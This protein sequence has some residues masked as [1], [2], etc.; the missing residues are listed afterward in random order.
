MDGLQAFHQLKTALT[1]AAALHVFSIHCDARKDGI[2]AVLVQ[3]TLEGDGVPIAFMSQKRS[4]SIGTQSDASPFYDS[5]P[6]SLLLPCTE[7][8]VKSLPEYIYRFKTKNCSLEKV[9][10]YP[11]I[12]GW[13]TKRK[14]NHF[15]SCSS[16][17][18]VRIHEV[19]RFRG[20]VEP[21][22][23][24]NGIIPFGSPLSGEEAKRH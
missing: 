5:D 6:T 2:H 10:G 15:R 11:L 24:D 12:L 8:G 23:A 1:S 9:I 4:R 19:S 18:L 13:T 7:K 3:I 16:T 20:A 21:V 17:L 14:Y 22:L